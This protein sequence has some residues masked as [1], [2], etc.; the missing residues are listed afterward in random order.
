MRIEIDTDAATLTC[1][2]SSTSRSIG[3]YTREAFEIIAQQYLRLG[4]NQKYTYTF[5]WLGRPIIQL[6]DAAWSACRN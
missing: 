5:S 4:W 2:D 6:P 3:L 1:Q